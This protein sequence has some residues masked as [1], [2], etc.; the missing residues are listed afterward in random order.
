MT[1]ME[2]YQNYLAK[3]RT[4]IDP[5]DASR[6]TPTAGR[7]PF[8]D[9]SDFVPASLETTVVKLE[10]GRNLCKY[11]LN[12]KI[13]NHER[14]ELVELVQDIF[15]TFSIEGDIVDTDQ[16]SLSAGLKSIYHQDHSSTSKVF[17]A[18]NN[19]YFLLREYFPNYLNVGSHV[20]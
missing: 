6:P 7:L 10:M 15:H 9:L 18:N 1:F 2:P 20:G 11:P 12:G 19:K 8:I 16:Q 14:E 5:E 3:K 13:T 17:L 4:E